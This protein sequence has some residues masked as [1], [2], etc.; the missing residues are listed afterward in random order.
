MKAIVMA[1]GAGSRLGYVEKPMVKL[2]G[3]PLISWIIDTLMA[4]PSI[5]AV[6][7]AVSPRT[8]RTRGFCLSRGADVVETAGA[9]YEHDVVE[10]VKQVGGLALVAV[11]DVPL[12]TPTDVELLIEAWND[13]C[14]SSYVTTLATYC[15]EYARFAPEES[16][17]CID[18]YGLRV[19]PVGLSIFHLRGKGYKT[20]LAGFTPRYVN[21]N[22]YEGLR[23]AEKV[24]ERVLGGPHGTG[25]RG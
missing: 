11:S 15:D 13:C 23:L 12:I 19:Q 7:C 4:S 2:L 1:G 20:V 18:F 14:R 16:V 25:A 17:I 22:T 21:V 9:G 6:A 24:V 5:T 3:K 8:P 10:A